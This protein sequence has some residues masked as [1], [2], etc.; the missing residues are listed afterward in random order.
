MTI[1]GNTT[2]TGLSDGSHSIVIYSN[3]T[4]G[5]MGKSDTIFFEVNTEDST[6][7]IV[8]SGVI[9]IA[10]GVGILVYFKKRK[11]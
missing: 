7:P 5:N 11:H 4:L 1:A 2:L 3:D 6:A 8:L 9:V 10:I